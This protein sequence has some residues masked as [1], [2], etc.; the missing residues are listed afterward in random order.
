MKQKSTVN[1]DVFLFES[2]AVQSN[3]SN[4]SVLT[5]QSCILCRSQEK[6]YIF[7]LLWT[8]GAASHD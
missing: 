6:L 2:A 3:S 4:I 1:Q 7:Y 5:T 8:P